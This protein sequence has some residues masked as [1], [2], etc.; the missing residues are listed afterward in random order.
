MSYLA[1]LERKYLNALEE[2]RELSK[3][4]IEL[5][6][7]IDDLLQAPEVPFRLRL[8][9]REAKLLS[10][11]MSGVLQSKEQLLAKMY[12]DRFIDDEPEI[13][14]VDVYVCKLRKKLSPLG[15]KI[16]T[17]YGQGYFLP[18]E[19]RQALRAM[20]KEDAMKSAA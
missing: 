8:T 7:K 1:E 6:A 19:T 3:R 12:A 20:S 15:L 4:A 11:L 18:P 2:I 10:A 13:K 17:A 14:I 9:G 16:K 5:Q